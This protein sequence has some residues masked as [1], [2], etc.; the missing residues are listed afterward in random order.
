MIPEYLLTRFPWL[1][2]VVLLVVALV[3]VVVLGFRS[4]LLLPLI[5]AA[6]AIIFLSLGSIGGPAGNSKILITFGLCL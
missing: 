2:A 4:P 3:L 5:V 6:A 1:P